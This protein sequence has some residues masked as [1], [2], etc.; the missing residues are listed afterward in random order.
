MGP[1]DSLMVTPRA[2]AVA[3]AALTL[4]LMSNAVRAQD[5][6]VVTTSE[7]AVSGVE[8]SGVTSYLGIP[9]AAPPV[10]NLRWIPPQPPARHP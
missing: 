3:V 5:S 10:G 8:R 1:R 7:G 4:A 2:V 6:R 9:F